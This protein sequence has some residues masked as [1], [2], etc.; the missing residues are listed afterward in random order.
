[1]IVI[2]LALVSP[3]VELLSLYVANALEDVPLDSCPIH[4]DRSLGQQILIAN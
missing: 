2:H 4:A 1:M 3:R